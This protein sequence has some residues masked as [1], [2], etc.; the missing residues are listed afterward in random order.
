M[1]TFVV[2]SLLVMTTVTAR[3]IEKDWIQSHQITGSENLGQ[4]G[5]DYYLYYYEDETE[6]PH[7]ET[8]LSDCNGADETQDQPAGSVE[9]LDFPLL[10]KYPQEAAITQAKFFCNCTT[11][12]ET[13]ELLEHVCSAP[14]RSLTRHP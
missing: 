6:A 1:K 11:R 4:E 8:E 5:D 14:H 2:L 9:M 13:L 7:V 12:A 10:S 3:D